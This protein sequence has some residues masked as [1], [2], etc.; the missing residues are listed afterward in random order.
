MTTD[1]NLQPPTEA[2]NTMM[3]PRPA[4]T[5]LRASVKTALQDYL[6]HVD[7]ELVTDLQQGG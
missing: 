4:A 5:P 7:A 1:A 3:T 2:G 6:E